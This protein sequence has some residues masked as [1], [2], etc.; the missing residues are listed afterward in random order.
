MSGRVVVSSEADEAEMMSFD[1][2]E[3]TE[4]DV[5]EKAR[6]DA[7]YALQDLEQVL[8]NASLLPPGDEASSSGVKDFAYIRPGMAEAVRVT[9]DPAYFEEHADSVELW[10]P[11]APLFPDMTEVGTEDQVTEGEFRKIL[12]R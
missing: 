4:G 3:I 6:P 10:P 2:D 7:P 5:E 12:P 9:T 1:L 11:G 8:R